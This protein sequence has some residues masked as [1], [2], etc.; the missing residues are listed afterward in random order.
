MS[1]AVSKYWLLPWM[2]KWSCFNFADQLSPGECF[3]DFNI[4]TEPTTIA[5]TP[6]HVNMG[7]AVP[8]KNSK[9]LLKKKKLNPV[10]RK[11]AVHENSFIALSSID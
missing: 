8:S 10:T 4:L 11:K 9:S 1:S 5:K 3:S 2:V 6:T 7:N